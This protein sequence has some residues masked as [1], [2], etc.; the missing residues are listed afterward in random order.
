RAP[1][2]AAR[3]RAQR[4]DVAGARDVGGL[5]VVGDRG[6]DRGRAVGRGDPGGD[7]VPK[8]EVFSQ[9]GTIMPRFS[10]SS[11]C[12]VIERQIRPRP[13]FAMKLIASGVTF[14]A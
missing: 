10:W 13:Y 1:Q 9:S 4:E 12:S 14:S 2:H 6:E 5:R 3:S 7:A 11:W 8:P